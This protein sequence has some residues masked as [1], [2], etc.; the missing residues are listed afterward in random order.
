MKSNDSNLIKTILKFHIAQKAQRARNLNI[1]L[2]AAVS[3]VEGQLSNISI[4]LKFR[5]TSAGNTGEGNSINGRQNVE[6][7]IKQCLEV[8]Q[9]LVSLNTNMQNSIM[10]QCFYNRKSTFWCFSIFFSQVFSILDDDRD[11]H[12]GAL[13]KAS[14]T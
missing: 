6:Q 11:V 12:D 2:N 14:D 8:H 13:G 10:L 1:F 9:L 5:R 7:P 4:K 3:Q